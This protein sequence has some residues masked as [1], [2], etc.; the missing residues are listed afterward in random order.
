MARRVAY[1]EANL[2]R[3]G[4][5]ILDAGATW[6]LEHIDSLSE[7]VRSMIGDLN[8]RPLLPLDK[9]WEHPDDSKFEQTYSQ[10]YMLM[11]F[12]EQEYGAPAITRLL[13]TVGSA[14]SFSEAIEKGL[15]IPFAEFD[16]KWQ[17]W[18]KKILT[19]LT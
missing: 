1:G 14:P 7:N 13:A 2:E 19:P 15:G 18:T 11:H 9:L 3:P 6:A 4:Q 10:A 8:Q 5:L 17:I 12:I 16:L